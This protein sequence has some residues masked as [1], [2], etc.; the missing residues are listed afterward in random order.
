MRIDAKT[1]RAN[2]RTYIRYALPQSSW[3]P[4]WLKIWQEANPGK[5]L[6]IK[7]AK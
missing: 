2:Q 4:E 6:L 1:A 3:H 5:V 7:G